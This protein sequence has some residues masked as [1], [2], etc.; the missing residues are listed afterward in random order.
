MRL[1]DQISTFPHD[2]VG[3]SSAE[4]QDLR[5]AIIDARRQADEAQT[6]IERLQHQL[7]LTI[8]ERTEAEERY[9][10]AISEIDAN[11]KVLKAALEMITYLAG[12]A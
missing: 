4:V 12:R 2:N 1:S 11:D 3:P 10:H 5:D 9:I 8:R 6:K 7:D